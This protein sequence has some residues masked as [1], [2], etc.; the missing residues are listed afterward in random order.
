MNARGMPNYATLIQNH[1]DKKKSVPLASKSVL[2]DAT[3]LRIKIALWININ[4]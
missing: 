2:F 1:V 3:I 4:L